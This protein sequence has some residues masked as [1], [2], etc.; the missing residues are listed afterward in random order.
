MSIEIKLM[1]INQLQVSAT[2]WQFGAKIYI[3]N[4]NSLKNHK[5]AHNSTTT[6]AGEKISID[7]ESLEI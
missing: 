4:F 1:R 5:F 2:R 3:C 6:K 7:L